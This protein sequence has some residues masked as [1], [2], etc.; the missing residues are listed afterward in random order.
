M[1]TKLFDYVE[2]H[3]FIYDL[4]GVTKFLCFIFASCA[5]M[6]S[7]DIR[8]VSAA[9]LLSLV[10]LKVSGITFS[11]IKVMVYYVAVFILLN[12]VLTFLFS[13]LYGVEIYGTRHELFTVA[14]RYVMTQEQLLYQA[15]KVL[16]YCAVLPL[17]IIFLLATNPSEMAASLSRSGIP[18]KASFALALTLRYFPDV[19]RD[20]NDISLAQQSR[21]LDL[22]KKEK[23]GVRIKNT[24]NICV[25]LIFSTLDRI[26]LISNTMDLRGFGMK[27][28]RTWYSEKKICKQDA[29]AL[30]VCLLL[31]MIS[32]SVTVF[33]NH[34]RFYNP[35]V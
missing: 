4:S 20:Y 11:Q 26:E 30:T 22:S 1:N 2:R 25:P 29:A 8:V 19:I 27:K 16:K 32:V 7:Y 14:G 35:F 24:M 12:A 13:P 21:G 5:V 3:N 31:L 17:G 18:Y 28:R 6:Y 15:T 23:L 10:S 34:S 33:I 9:L